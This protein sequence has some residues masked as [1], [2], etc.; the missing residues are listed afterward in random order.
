MKK[1]YKYYSLLTFPS[2]NVVTT[3]RSNWYY[4][5]SDISITLWNN[6]VGVDN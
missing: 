5:Y 1:L 3:V 6:F 4:R 2:N